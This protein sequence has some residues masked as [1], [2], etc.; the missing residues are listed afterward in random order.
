M[1]ASYTQFS[2]LLLL[3]LMIAC[4]N[5]EFSSQTSG[6]QFSCPH[7]RRGPEPAGPTS[8]QSNL[9]PPFILSTEVNSESHVNSGIEVLYCHHTKYNLL[10]VYTV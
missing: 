10:G 2:V 5:I 7:C 4:V 1:L 6:V 8:W 3:L 9:L